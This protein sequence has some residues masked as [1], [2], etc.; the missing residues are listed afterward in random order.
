MALMLSC[1]LYTLNAR[2]PHLAHLWADRAFSDPGRVPLY[3]TGNAPQKFPRTPRH[4][5]GHPA[6]A[7]PVGV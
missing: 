5:A 1:Y 2:Y 3:W 6:M 7:G 4:G